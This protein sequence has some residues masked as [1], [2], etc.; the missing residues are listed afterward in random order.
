MVVIKESQLTDAACLLSTRNRVNRFDASTVDG[1]L[2][3]ENAYFGGKTV[4]H[5]LIQ[6]TENEREYYPLIGLL[7]LV[8][9]EIED[10]YLA[11]GGQ[12]AV[13][14]GI[15]EA[16][17]DNVHKKII[18]SEEINEEKC[19]KELALLKGEDRYGLE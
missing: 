3:T 1:A 11:V 7:S 16:D 9:R 6:K 8:I 13:G 5:I 12:T 10:G 15:F 4:L 14:R 2:Y 18:W 17:T 19:L